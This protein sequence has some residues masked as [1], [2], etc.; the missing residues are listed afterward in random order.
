MNTFWPWTL[1][2][3]MNPVIDPLLE[4]IRAEYLL[5]RLWKGV[6]ERH[7]GAIVGKDRL[8]NERASVGGEVFER[9]QRRIVEA[10]GC[11][12]A[13]LYLCHRVVET[14]DESD[15]VVRLAGHGDGLDLYSGGAAVLQIGDAKID[16][17]AAGDDAV[18]LGKGLFDRLKLAEKIV[19][20]DVP[21]V[22]VRA[23]DLER[24]TVGS[25]RR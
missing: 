25:H 5:D 10:T 4:D 14:S 13:H 23:A 16:G 22:L 15:G 12:F 24:D 6:G 2:W 20:P 17:P 1:I 9:L 3:S 21:V 18:R 7:R 11:L 19:E 8:T